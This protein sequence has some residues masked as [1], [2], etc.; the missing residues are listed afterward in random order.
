[1]KKNS[2]FKLLFFL[3]LGF[4]TEHLFAQSPYFYTIDD[5]E[6]LPSNE[7]YQLKQD[8]F[9]FMWIASDAGLF[10]YDGFHYKA[11]TH[12]KQ[13]SIS[14]SN[15]SIDPKQNVW[16][17]NFTG[18]IFNTTAKKDQFQLIFD[19]S[20]NAKVTP[21]YTVDTAANAWIA[22]DSAV[23]VVDANGNQLKNYRPENWGLDPQQVW[24]DIEYHHSSAKIYLL[25]YKAELVVLNPETDEFEVFKIRTAA[26]NR[27]SLFNLD[28]R[29]ILFV[30]E[31]PIR[32]YRVFDVT[33][34][35]A[36]P[37]ADFPPLSP[38]GISY[39]I[40]PFQ[41]WFMLCTSSGAILLDKDYK[42]VENYP[43]FFKKH[44]VSYSYTDK[45]KNTWFSSLQ[46]GIFVVPSIDV[47]FFNTQ[48]SILK[49]DNIS[50]LAKVDDSTIIIGSYLGDLYQLNTKQ[51]QLT[52]IKEKQEG[53]YRAVRKIHQ[54]GTKIYVARG[55]FTIIDKKGKT[56]IVRALNNCRDFQL[57]N[58]DTIYYTRSDV[59]GFVSRADGEWKQHILKNTGGKKVIYD[60]LH[61][62]TYYACTNGLYVYQKGN[63]EE[64]K[65]RG[66]AIYA[67]SFFLDKDQLWIGTNNKGGL[68]LSNGDFIKHYSDQNLLLDNNVRA[69]YKQ[70]DSLWVASRNGLNLI[71]LK[72]EKLAYY[73]EYDGFAFKEVSSLL[74]DQGYLYCSTIKALVRVPVDLPWKNE[75]A[76]VINLVSIKEDNEELEQLEGIELGYKN[77]NLRIDFI[78][79]A[80]RSRQSFHYEY[81]LEGFENRWIKIPASTAYINFPTLPPGDYNL[82]VQAVNEDQLASGKPIQL[83]IHVRFALWQKWWFYLMSSLIFIT[84]I[85]FIFRVRLFAIK[86]RAALEN[87]LIASQLTA[88]KAQMNP[89]F[90]YNA[91]NSI[92]ALNAKKETAKANFYLSKFSQLM[93]KILE[94]SGEKFI[95]LQDEIDWLKIYLELEKLRF[96]DDFSFEF[97]VGDNI[98]TH[99]IWMPSMILQPF[100][101]NA[102]KHGLLHKK[103]DRKLNIEFQLEGEKLICKIKDNGVGRKKVEE[104][105]ARLVKNH[106][107]FATQAT[108]KRIELLN[109]MTKDSYSFELNDLYEDNQAAGTLVKIQIPILPFGKPM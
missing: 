23:L 102:I 81:R 15:I 40:T 80:F 100:I 27:L 82:E 34:G 73:N 72:E 88:L 22:T 63:L 94:A 11:Y 97:I 77:H 89:H 55:L 21:V 49:D 44:K 96:G 24:F 14:L 65:F 87:K 9:G 79:T 28:N 101:E 91:L 107:S 56:E 1:M 67:S 31:L 57:V 45:E 60:P 32:Y 47:Q 83:A 93:R 68:L 39:T 59:S 7:V 70:G 13:N 85:F 10:R 62:A 64:I 18:Q 8:S 51:Y 2:R 5:E 99:D 76:A 104:I 38:S 16:C 71:H 66:E 36:N 20:E 58:S 84:I 3:V 78:A 33:N 19:G 41:D 95:L 86:R 46:D 26:A 43:I 108:E 106:Q 50:T 75:V 105:K 92:Q 74:V 69:I 4:C 61:Q 103:S 6:G 53:K 48:N 37:L 52:E 109:Q 54:Q 35:S 98:D 12:P 17:Q 25:N 90:L 29:I 42:P 30:E